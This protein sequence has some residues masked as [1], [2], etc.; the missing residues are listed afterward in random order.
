MKNFHSAFFIV[1]AVAAL[2]FSNMHAANAA[3]A[4]SFSF[5]TGNVAFAY[6]DGYWDRSH[7]WHSWRN[8]REAREYRTH[9]GYNYK[10]SK[11]TRER[12]KGWRNDTDHDGIPNQHDR[13]RDGDG[14]SNRRD[15]APD[16]ARR[17]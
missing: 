7:Q 1:G 12:N 2:T 4:F 17:N 3:D 13:D 9:Y 6:S 5:D 15:D 11:H 8:T 16:N 14:V 10:A